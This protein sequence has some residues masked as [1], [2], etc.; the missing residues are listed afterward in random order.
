[1]AFHF[2][3]NVY[4][5]PGFGYTS[6]IGSGSSSA[7]VKNARS[8]SAY[9]GNV[10]GFEILQEIRHFQ[11]GFADASPVSQYF[12]DPDPQSKLCTV[13]VPSFAEPEQKPVEQQLFARTGAGDGYVNSYKTL[14]FSYQSL[15]LT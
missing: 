10:N 1:M 14:N 7:F 4:F 8:G 2:G 6:G 12:L 13:P 5:K 9:T 11:S 3:K 15:K